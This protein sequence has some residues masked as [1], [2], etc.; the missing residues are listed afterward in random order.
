MAFSRA[1]IRSRRSPVLL[2]SLVLTGLSRRRACSLEKMISRWVDG[3]GVAL[4]RTC[5][6]VCMDVKSLKC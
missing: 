1:L 2:S 6:Y 3:R 5:V 4:L